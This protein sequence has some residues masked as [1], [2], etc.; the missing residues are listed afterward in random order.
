MN[1]AEM[2]TTAIELVALGKGILAVDESGPTM[3]KRFK[4]VGVQSTEATRRAYREMLLST[5][6]LG[7]FVS[8]VIL[9][10]ETLRQKTAAGVPFAELVVAQGMIPGIKVDLGTRPLAGS[11]KE[12]ITCIRKQSSLNLRRLLQAPLQSVTIVHSD[13]RRLKAR[14]CQV[15]SGSKDVTGTFLDENVGFIRRKQSSLKQGLFLHW[16]MRNACLG[17]A[18]IL[19]SSGGGGSQSLG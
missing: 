12:K 6:G 19:L 2:E 1:T 8:G 16:E 13:I 5:P 9:F 7:A 4:Q 11:P 18:I 15:W 3:E 14:T 10:D 17:A